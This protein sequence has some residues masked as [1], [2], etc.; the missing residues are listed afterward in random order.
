MWW[1]KY[2][3]ICDIFYCK[4]LL[5]N[6]IWKIN[7]WKWLLLP[8]CICP[9]TW[10]IDTKWWFNKRKYQIKTILFNN[11]VRYFSHFLKL[12]FEENLCSVDPSI[13]L[14]RLF[15]ILVGSNW[16]LEKTNQSASKWFSILSSVLSHRHCG[17]IKFGFKLQN[18][19]VERS[20]AA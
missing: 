3:Y 4:H 19:R 10:N 1:T 17:T 11:Q 2:I 5:T 18:S 16:K 7:K 6:F 15:G 13:L 8:L 20:R 9:N 12:L 14:M